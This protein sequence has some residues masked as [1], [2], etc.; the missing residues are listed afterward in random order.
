[1]SDFQPEAVF[2]QLQKNIHKYEYARALPVIPNVAKES[3]RKDVCET[4][5]FENN[6]IIMN[7]EF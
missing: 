6:L 3:L 1:M 7:G 2:R 5:P 4:R